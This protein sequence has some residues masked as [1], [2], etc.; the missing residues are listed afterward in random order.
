MAH[1]FLPFHKHKTF[2]RN[3]NGSNNAHRHRGRLIRV[4]YTIVWS[5]YRPTSVYHGIIWYNLIYLFM[6]V[7]LRPTRAYEHRDKLV[8][9]QWSGLW[10]VISLQTLC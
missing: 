3:S 1:F 10:D 7:V 8:T 4:G 9:L 5:C 6:T 2:S